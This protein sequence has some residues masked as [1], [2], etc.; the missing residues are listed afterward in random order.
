VRDERSTKAEAFAS[1]RGGNQLS[2]DDYVV[3]AQR[4]P[5]R[6]PR[7]GRASEVVDAWT[8]TGAQRRPRRSPRQGEVLVVGTRNGSMRST[9]AEAFASARVVEWALDR[10][11]VPSRST[12]AEAFASARV[13]DPASLVDV[14]VLRSTKAEAF[15][16]ARVAVDVGGR[17][18]A[19]RSTKAEAFASARA[20]VADRRADAGIRSTKA[21]AFASARA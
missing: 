17:H 8:T 4:R 6:S 10:S 15:A 1:A 11:L 5:R 13:G 20:V 18:L 7:Q 14:G 2:L 21:E 9:K 3:L 19:R 12:K 16:S